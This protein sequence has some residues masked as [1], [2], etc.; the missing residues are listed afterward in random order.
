MV[1]AMSIFITILTLSQKALEDLSCSP[2][3][4][5]LLKYRFSVELTLLSGLRNEASADGSSSLYSRF[6]SERITFIISC[7]H[8]HS[9][10]SELLFFVKYHSLLPV[11]L[12]DEPLLSGER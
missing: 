8:E 2:I 4:N 9:M 12:V 1:T 11:H 10:L 7:F 5:S 3:N 6:Q